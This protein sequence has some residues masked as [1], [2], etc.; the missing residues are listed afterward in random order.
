MKVLAVNTSRI[1][2]LVSGMAV[3][4]FLRDRFGSVYVLPD[5]RYAGILDA[6]RGIITVSPETARN[7]RF[8]LII[9][10]SSTK[11]SARYVRTI[12]AGEKISLYSTFLK[13]LCAIPFSDVRL[14]RN[15]RNIVRTY[16][17]VLRYFGET[18][19]LMPSLSDN[20]NANALR[21]LEETRG[22][23]KLAG[24]HFDAA[25]IRRILPESLVTGVIESLR[26]RGIGVILLGTGGEMARRLVDRSGGYAFWR[27]LT[28]PEVKTVIAGLDLFIGTDSGLLHMAAA[29]G[30]PS[31]GLYGPNVPGIS[32]P[33]APCVRFVELPLD[34]RPCNQ[35]RE[36]PHGVRCLED[37]SPERVAEEI[38]RIL[39][40]T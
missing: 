26:S 18:R 38:D 5:P 29:L 14:K 3:V 30:T 27:E 37:I 4:N 17:P 35:N 13:L 19:D 15:D 24:I 2:D 8:D 6:E 28:L 20:R 12:R 36:C 21:H 10:L 34:C 16:Y 31:I 32:G 1:G 33:P 22:G 40:L 25:S 11:N 9:D 39:H 7:Q 23:R